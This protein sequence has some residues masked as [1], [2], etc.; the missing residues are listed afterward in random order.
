MMKL[1]GG[2]TGALICVIWVTE[3]RGVIV[4]RYLV[5]IVCMLLLVAGGSAQAVSKRELEQRIVR[6]ERLIEQQSE[7]FLRMQQLQEEIR[8]MRGDLEV[9]AHTMEGIQRRQQ[10]FYR[11]LDS[12][13]GRLEQDTAGDTGGAFGSASAAPEPESMVGEEEQQAYQRAFEHLRKL[14]YP[15]AIKGFEDY[16]KAYPEGRY[17]AR[18]QYWLGEIRYV[19]GAYKQAV[20]EYRKLVERY[21]GSD[22]IPEVMLKIGLGYRELGKSG[23]AQKQLAAL[24]ARFP[25]SPEAAEAK[26]YLK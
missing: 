16:L 12:R 22:K 1:P 7:M 24:I 23:A 14:E 15:K 18:S 25:D 17:A 3:I 11:D 4:S 21:P 26:K 20:A 9:H 13:L 6:L 19:R 8:V 10:E 5:Y 2:K